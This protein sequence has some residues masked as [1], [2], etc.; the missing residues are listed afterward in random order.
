MSANFEFDTSLSR[1]SP[2]YE[3][4]K[5]AADAAKSKY[6]SNNAERKGLQK[7]FK[8]AVRNKD[9]KM[10]AG[11]TE[12]LEKRGYH[13]SG[14]PDR[15][16]EKQ[17]LLNDA[18][19]KIDEELGP[20]SNAPAESFALADQRGKLRG[21]L[22]GSFGKDAQQ[23]AINER[24]GTMG[25]NEF[26]QM[27][28]G[29][30]SVMSGDPEA[31][32]KAYAMGS[33]KA[34]VGQEEIDGFLAQARAP[35]LAAAAAAQKQKEEGA[36]RAAS[37]SA[38]ARASLSE[39]VQAR[40]S[41]R[42]VARRQQD[43]E[44]DQVFNATL[45]GMREPDAERAAANDANADRAQVTFGEF[46]AREIEFAKSAASREAAS[47]SRLSAAMEDLRVGG[48]LA[49]RE[50]RHL[51]RS[52]E[53]D[54]LALSED[55]QENAFTRMFGNKNKGTSDADSSR[56]YP[57]AWLTP[58]GAKAMRNESNADKKARLDSLE[59][60]S[61]PTPGL[62]DKL[63]RGINSRLAKTNKAE[64]DRKKNK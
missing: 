49:A 41:E 2:T 42:M 13:T 44:S 34:G 26:A 4:D 62:S 5:M 61:D 3:R 15:A 24:D 6:Q 39:R 43:A 29:S 23:K 55:S 18:N 8:D 40:L 50:S 28:R 21:A 16:D 32:K 51:A 12:Q 64:E 38:N 14:R 11:F 54:L 10:A 19:R 37:F 46:Q 31:L 30:K 48:E 56:L 35:G 60:Q 59:D 7:G 63:I 17:S 9:Y 27:L 47:A 22:D 57:R 25:R 36:A 58:E 1:L 33:D 52:T 53:K 45:D 20:R